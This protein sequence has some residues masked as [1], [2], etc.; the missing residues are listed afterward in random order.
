MCAILVFMNARIAQNWNGNHSMIY[1]DIHGF[2]PPPDDACPTCCGKGTVPAD[3]HPHDPDEVCWVGD[4]EMQCPD[5]V[6]GT[7]VIA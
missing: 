3:G 6:S 1:T 4:G 2:I 5:C 7:R